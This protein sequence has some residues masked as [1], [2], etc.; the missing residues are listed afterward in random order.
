MGLC[1]KETGV[2]NREYLIE[3]GLRAGAD[4]FGATD[5]VVNRLYLLDHD[6]AGNLASARSLDAQRPPSIGIGFRKGIV[7]VLVC[8]I[9]VRRICGTFFRDRGERCTGIRQRTPR[10]FS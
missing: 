4:G 1:L 3:D 8:T 9:G 7:A 2:E 6:D 5:G 10:R